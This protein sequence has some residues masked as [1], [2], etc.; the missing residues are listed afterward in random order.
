MTKLRRFPKVLADEVR[1]AMADVR[2]LAP[3]ADVMD[4]LSRYRRARTKYI[5]EHGISGI[6]SPSSVPAPAPVPLELHDSIRRLDEAFQKIHHYNRGGAAD[7]LA[8]GVMR[9]ANR[10]IAKR[11]RGLEERCE[12]EQIIFDALMRARYSDSDNKKAIK[13]RLMSNLGI[14]QYQISKVI[15][16]YGLAR[17]KKT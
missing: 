16:N 12:Q 15:R 11:S 4:L 7:Y 17:K 6:Y 5:A 10:A 3:S 9:A 2:R 14:T 13:L 8:D 1:D